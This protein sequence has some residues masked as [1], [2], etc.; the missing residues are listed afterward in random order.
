MPVLI[1]LGSATPRAVDA[2]EENPSIPQE[3]AQD[4]PIAQ[5]L[6]Q[7][8]KQGAHARLEWGH[9]PDFQGHLE[10]LYQATRYT[11]LWTHEGKPTRQAR[12]A[13]TILNEAE[14][15]G[16]KASDYDAKYLADG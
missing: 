16:L 2:I 5:G 6:H 9:F 10:H 7:L 1:T 14:M 8:L 12:T 15:H 11:L 4:D 13:V 3:T